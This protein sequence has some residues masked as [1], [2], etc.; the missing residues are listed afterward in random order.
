MPRVGKIGIAAKRM[1][2]RR[3]IGKLK[4]KTPKFRKS[5]VTKP[6]GRQSHPT[7]V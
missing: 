7:T 5:K 1:Q 6:W 3:V 4:D 2:V